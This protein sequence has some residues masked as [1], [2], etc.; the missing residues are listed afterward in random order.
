[1]VLFVGGV[2]SAGIL[3][4]VHS[5][6]EARKLAAESF[7]VLG[8]T[9]GTSEVTD[10]ERVL[11]P[12]TS[13]ETPEHEGLVTCYCSPGSDRTVLEFDSWVGTIVEFRFF[14]GSP[15]MV[16]RCAK[17]R[18]V[19]NSLATASGLRLGMSRSQI[20]A[21]L[22]TPTEVRED[23]FIY[24]STYDR[25]PTPE[26]VKHFNDAFY[27]PPALINVHERV[28]IGFRGGRVVRV[29]VLRAKGW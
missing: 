3:A 15:Q 5:P 4:G 7:Q 6:A 17:S 22:G 12:G 21:L 25:P 8:I 1:V 24:D 14:Q 9:L 19:S 13:R 23:R 26:E 18:F 20:M 27:A 10:L 11:G 2:A 29:D 16:S 28:D